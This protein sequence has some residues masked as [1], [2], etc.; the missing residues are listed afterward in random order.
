MLYAAMAKIDSSSMTVY[1]VKERDLDK[2]PE[3]DRKVMKKLGVHLEQI[4]K[5]LTRNTENNS[6]LRFKLF[7]YNMLRVR[8][9]KKCAWCDCDV[10]QMIEGA[11]IWPVFSIKKAVLEDSI[12]KQAATDGDN[13]IWLCRNHHKLFD[14]DIVNINPKKLVLQIINSFSS[15]SYIK[16]SIS[17]ND[18][19]NYIDGKVSKEYLEQ[20]YS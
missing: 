10:P 20:R 11:H 13:G 3:P 17:C 1:Q 7:T 8:G 19:S 4:D 2:L 6:S 16:N 15:Y 14:A 12:K 5:G 9:A 18:A